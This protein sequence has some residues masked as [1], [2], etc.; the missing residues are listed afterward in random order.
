MFFDVRFGGRRSA[1][2]AVHNAVPQR[3]CREA[4]TLPA[5]TNLA[6]IAGGDVVAFIDYPNLAIPLEKRG[7][8]LS[9]H[10]AARI[11]ELAARSCLWMVLSEIDASGDYIRQCERAGANVLVI[12][13]ERVPT[14]RGLELKANADFDLVGQAGRVLE[15]R[16]VRRG[17][18]GHLL[19]GSGDGD[20]TVALARLAARASRPRRVHTLAVP[21]SA[22]HRQRRADLFHGGIALGLDLTRPLLDAQ[23]SQ[24]HLSKEQGSWI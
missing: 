16:P 23:S 21:G 13:A 18:V 15:R 6:A 24:N 17:L 7:L 12:P 11:R 20:L 1:R 3:E 4:P 22:S 10:L 9:A 19:V 8:E 14:R 2:A 5:T